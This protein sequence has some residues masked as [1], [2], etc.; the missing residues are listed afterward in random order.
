MKLSIAWIFDHID[1]DWQKINISKLVQEFNST[2]AEIEGVEKISL[3]QNQFSLVKITAIEKLTSGHSEEWKQEINLAN[4][5]DAKEGHIFLVF[6]KDDGEVCW[7]SSSDISGTK[8]DILP[9]LFCAKEELDGSWKKNIEWNDYILELDNKTITNRPDMWG[10]RG[11][12]REIAAILKLEFKDLDQFILPAK[13]KDFGQTA[14]ASGNMPITIDNKVPEACKRFSGVYIENVAHY[15]SSIYMVFRLSKIDFRAIDLLVDITNYVMS[16]MSQPLHVFDVDKLSDMQIMPRMARKGEKLELLDGKIISLDVTDLV[17]TD[18]LNPIALAGVIG[19]MKS[20][21]G[22]TTKRIFVESANFDAST[23][24][25]SAIR[26]KLRTESS[27]RFEKG[28]DL[29]QNIVGLK[30]FLRLLSDAKIP[31]F[32]ISDI[33]STGPYASEH[34]IDIGHKFLE[35]R[36]GSTIESTFVIKTLEKLGFGV[37]ATKDGSETVYRVTVPSFR[38]THITIVEDI[39][40]EIAR[41]FGYTNIEH[42]LPS[43]SIGVTNIEPLCFLRSAK[44][45]FAYALNMTEVCHYALYDEAF[46]D[47]IGWHPEQEIA[48]KNPVSQNWKFL[49]TSL[50]PHLFKA[51]S[52]NEAVY[53]Q[54]S[55]FEFGRIWH[56]Y[57][58]R[59]EHGSGYLV[60]SGPFILE[61]KSFV[62][63]FFDAKNPLDFYKE[64]RKLDSFFHMIKL[65]IEWAKAEAGSLDTWYHEYQSSNLIYNG[66]KIGTVGMVSPL[67]FSHI[68]AGNAFIFELDGD[69]LLNYH[70]PLI[71][72]KAPSKYPYVWLDISM[73]VPQAVMASQLDLVI[74]SVDQRIVSVQ[75]IDFFTKD[76]WKDK[77]SLTFRFIVQDETKTLA[78][79]EIDSLSQSV[80]VAV[81]K[82]GAQVR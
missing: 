17:I 41:F 48:V 27:A 46:L 51:V 9:Q 66:E 45:Y 21:E 47:R 43:K 68:A 75:L 40:E 58:Q 77:K 28:L 5:P 69:F 7:A 15:S 33:I 67:F 26:Y 31:A 19:G 60:G 44:Q 73:L 42:Q 11:F 18:G 72:F 38:A 76:E 22:E 25:R 16:D 30:R 37:I 62:G 56:E 6:K 12:A 39:L 79:D 50:I 71:K 32:K 23:I 57:Q 8:N 59:P 63:I 2:T 29:N 34:T 70:S 3:N 24:R 1:A 54:S 74:K 14:Q 36:I 53:H 64:K 65:P 10:H 81:E 49:L 82:F 55:F 20:A 61:K 78:K 4:R 52:E 13:V 35:E 80:V